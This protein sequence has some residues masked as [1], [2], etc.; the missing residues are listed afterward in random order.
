MQEL[1]S[2]M[3]NEFLMW[4][5]IVLL[6]ILLVKTIRK[7][8][9]YRQYSR[10]LDELKENSALFPP[11]ANQIESYIFNNYDA[12]IDRYLRTKP[13][14]AFK[15]AEQIKE[16]NSKKRQ[17]IK[18]LSLALSRIDLYESIAP[19][20]VEYEDV[21]VRDLIEALHNEKEERE[22][23]DQSGEDATRRYISRAEWNKLPRAKR[24]QLAL[25]RYLSPDRKRSSWSAGILYER[26]IGYTYEKHGYKV[27]YYGATKGRADLGI[28]LV[29]E[30]DDKILVIQCKRLS[31]EKGLP[32]RENTIAQIYGSAQFY[33]M[34][35]NPQKTVKPVI[36]TTYKLS[37]EAH[38]FANYLGVEVRENVEL[39]PYPLIKCN[40]S[41]KNREKIYHLPMDQMYDK[42]VVEPERG[43]LYALT[44][45][46]A[47]K[48]GFR[49]AFRWRGKPKA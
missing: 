22:A 39:E 11:V 30:N 5:I 37:P 1:F 29:A 33:K 21:S 42:T 36:V 3:D 26:F 20:L 32:V 9:T 28:D 34:N 40:I 6:I 12:V 8:Q 16:A 38:N 45:E 19:W 14:P 24:N 15:A 31:K 17:A 4:G 48:A 47:E 10:K 13:R 46:E 2:W 23:I 35:N 44:V 27:E 25:D 49:R 41:K 7:H 43:E 18:D